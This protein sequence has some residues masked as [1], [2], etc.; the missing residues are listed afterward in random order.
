MPHQAFIVDGVEWP[1]VTAI[2]GASP[3][4]WLDRW[5]DKWGV[6]A[7]RKMQ[8]AANVGTVFH[9]NAELLARGLLVDYTG[10][11]ARR[12][13]AM[14]V[15]FDRWLVESGFK[16]KETELHVVSE[17]YKYHGTFDATGYLA[18]RPLT[19][20]LFDWKTSSGIYEDMSLQ[21]AAYAQ[22]Y[23]EQTGVEIKRGIIV[24]VSKAKPTHKL[25]VK[26]YKLNKTLLRKFLRRLREFNETVGVGLE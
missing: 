7:E 8:A 9:G 1:S 24:H 22:A 11:G 14:L 16:C 21:L 5:R 20:A 26:E 23:K 13:Y 6:L 15:Q 2:L 18:D 19:L 25:T 4:P 17:L 3:K 10:P 12:V